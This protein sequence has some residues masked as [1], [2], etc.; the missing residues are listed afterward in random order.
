MF[1]VRD[2]QSLRASRTSGPRLAKARIQPQ[3]NVCGWIE[4]SS[5]VLKTRQKPPQILDNRRFLKRF[6]AS[7]RTLT[8]MS[9]VFILGSL[10]NPKKK[11]IIAVDLNSNYKCFLQWI[12]WNNSSETKRILDPP[13]TQHSSTTVDPV[14]LFGFQ[15]LLTLTSHKTSKQNSRL[16]HFLLLI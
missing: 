12:T 7:P 2:S 1:I 4:I 9:T 6:L 3:F 15:E 10:G 16:S 11:T 14:F 13:T 5:R 8:S